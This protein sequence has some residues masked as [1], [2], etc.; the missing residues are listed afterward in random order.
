MLDIAAI[1]I[2]CAL[3]T[4]ALGVGAAWLA[5]LRLRGLHRVLPDRPSLAPQ[6]WLVLP[7]APAVMHRQLVTTARQTAKA[8]KRIS[9]EQIGSLTH[10]LID[11]LIAECARL[12]DSLAN[13]L[14]LAPQQR[15]VKVAELSMSVSRV[16]ALS[17]RAVA[18]LDTSLHSA[19]STRRLDDLETL[20]GHVENAKSAVADVQWP[21]SVSA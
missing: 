8:R 3:G 17:Q 5:T 20:I 11:G 13:T 19:D 2:G 16:Q 18:L 4:I 12:D 1:I 21:S 15:R 6:R 10:E 7:T 9:P 14:L